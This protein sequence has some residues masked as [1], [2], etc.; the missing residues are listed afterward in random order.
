MTSLPPIPAH[1]ATARLRA[2]RAQLIAYQQKIPAHSE[3]ASLTRKL[4]ARLDHQ[5][6]V[7]ADAEALARW[8]ALRRR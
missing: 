7:F 5:L 1:P 2:E 8:E 4:I 3:T 6:G